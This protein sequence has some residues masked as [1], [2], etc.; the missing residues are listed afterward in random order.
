MLVLFVLLEQTGL[1]RNE[2]RASIEYRLTTDRSTH[3]LSGDLKG[4]PS[5]SNWHGKR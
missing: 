3:V 4:I 2:N 5:D 1:I